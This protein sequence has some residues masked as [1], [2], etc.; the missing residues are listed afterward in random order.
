MSMFFREECLMPEMPVPGQH[1]G[2]P[3][4]VGSFNHFIVAH[5]AAWLDDCRSASFCRSQ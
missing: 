5:G 3:S 2:K 1:H 4:L